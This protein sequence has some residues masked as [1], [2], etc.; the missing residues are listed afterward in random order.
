MIGVGA[1]ARPLACCPTWDGLA[2]SEIP[3]A[4]KEH[5]NRENKGRNDENGSGKIEGIGGASVRKTD[6]WSHSKIM[7]PLFF[8]HWVR[9]APPP[10]IK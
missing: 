7:F 5:E 6:R 2:S 10:P 4:R 1:S 8:G 9:V 3:S